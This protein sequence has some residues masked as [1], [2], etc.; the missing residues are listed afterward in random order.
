[1][2]EKNARGENGIDLRFFRLMLLFG[3]LIHSSLCGFFIYMQIPVLIAYNIVSSMIYLG[4]LLFVARVRHVDRWF[5]LLFLEVVIHAVLCN[6]YLGW[7][8]GFALYGL[9]LVPM[10]YYMSSSDSKGKNGVLE[11]NILAFT[12]LLILGIS[13]LNTREF[14][15]FAMF[16]ERAVMIVFCI[17]LTLCVIAIIIYCSHFVAKIRRATQYLEERNEELDF[18]AHYDPVTNMRNRHNMGEVFREFDESGQPYCVILGD[19][20]DFKK[21]N[22]KYGH[23]CGDELLVNLSYI[24]RQEVRNRGEVCRWG[25]DEILL[26]LKM[27]EK[28][29]YH[30]IE[31]LRQ[32]IKNFV[33]EYE[34]VEVSTTM[35]FGFT[36]SEEGVSTEKLI[37]LADV[38]MHEGKWNGKNVTVGK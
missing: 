32:T 18:L 1:M 38:R 14:N 16:R 33:M 30:L 34:G 37:S 19:V 11:A 17:N 7:G 36:Y 15:R 25:G 8:Y 27:D 4:L 12:N 6:A 24:I 29:G 9:M 23:M 13:T 22:D 5:V 3:L 28:Q 31:H 26:L 10:A 21:I 20:D 2:R 35:T